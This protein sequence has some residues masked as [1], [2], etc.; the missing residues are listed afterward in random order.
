[1]VDALFHKRWRRWTVLVLALTF[2]LAALICWFTLKPQDLPKSDAFPSDKIAH[3]LAFFALIL[4]V[5]TLRPR[6]L[7]WVLPSAVT[8]GAA[9]EL[10][11][12]FL[13]RQ[14][15]WTDLGAN[16]AGL[17]IGL[18]VGFALHHLRLRPLSP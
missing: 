13:G 12:P 18:L 5:A 4:P 9:I 6:H 8:L 16:F 1:M 2:G 17:V 3:G 11:Q 15:E 10:L 7:W 14:G